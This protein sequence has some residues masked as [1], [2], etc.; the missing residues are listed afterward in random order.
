MASIYE[1]DQAA[2][3]NTN[4]APSATQAPTPKASSAGKPT[5][6]GNGEAPAPKSAGDQRDAGA[7]IL[8]PQDADLQDADVDVLSKAADSY[9][10]AIYATLEKTQDKAFKALKQPPLPNES[11]ALQILAAIS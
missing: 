11:Q 8:D 2:A 4:G 7:Q 1:S 9:V 10:N 5:I 6:L 3:K